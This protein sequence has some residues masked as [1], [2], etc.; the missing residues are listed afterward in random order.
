MLESTKQLWHEQKYYL[1]AGKKKGNK[2]N[3]NVKIEL[4]I[5]TW[6]NEKKNFFFLGGTGVWTQGSTLVKQALYHLHQTPS[7]FCSGYFG[8]GVSQTICPG[9]PQTAILQISASK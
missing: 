8:N 5:Q 4:K 2:I 7:P 9:W 3:S 6:T 1:N